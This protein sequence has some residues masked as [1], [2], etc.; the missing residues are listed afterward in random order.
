MNRGYARKHSLI[1]GCFSYTPKPRW[2]KNIGKIT[3]PYCGYKMQITY[4]EKAVCRGV[5]VRWKGKKCK[6]EFEIKID[7][8]K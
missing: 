6:K 5:F 8:V 7:K 2:V 3:C 1:G 4:N